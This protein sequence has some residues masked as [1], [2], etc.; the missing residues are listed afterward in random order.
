MNTYVFCIASPPDSVQQRCLARGL[1]PRHETLDNTQLLL[2]ECQLTDVPELLEALVGT[3]FALAPLEPVLEEGRR[4][5]CQQGLYTHFSRRKLPVYW[6][7]VDWFDAHRHEFKAGEHIV[8]LDGEL[9]HRTRDKQDHMRYLIENRNAQHLVHT[10][11][12][13]GVER[14]YRL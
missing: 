6:R 10:M 5:V 11:D 7:S 13:D 4:D 9:V 2:V 1:V 3:R 12:H 8:I 14:K